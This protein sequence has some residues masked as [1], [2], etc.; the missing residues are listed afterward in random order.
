MYSSDC[1]KKHYMTEEA[2]QG[3]KDIFSKP[4]DNLMDR[5][6]KS[7]ARYLLWKNNF[8]AT[9]KTIL[10]APCGCGRMTALFDRSSECNLIGIDCSKSMLE[11]AKKCV[12]NIKLIEGDIC[13]SVPIEEHSVS[14]I[15]SFRFLMN[16]KQEERKRVLIR[17]N[18]LLS[19]DG[20]L[21][22][23]VHL[24]KYSFRRLV[25][26]IKELFFREEKHPSLSFYRFKRDLRGADFELLGWVGANFLPVVFGKFFL[27][28][29]IFFRVEKFFSKLPILK[30][31]ATNLIFIAR[32]KN[33]K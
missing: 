29:E 19:S 8:T 23:N 15:I 1:Y 3:Y 10:D 12:D 2:V 22:C 27:P 11:E 9:H 33:K 28:K 14:L 5:L 16:I 13:V 4:F 25:Y 30:F 21:L 7:G 17:F 6:E 24:N 18:D 26:K 32:R 20:F 31:F